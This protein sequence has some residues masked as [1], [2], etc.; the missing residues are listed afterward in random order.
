MSGKSDTSR[1][2]ESGWTP[3]SASLGKYQV[4]VMIPRRLA[5]THSWWSDGDRC[6]DARALLLIRPTHMLGAY[7]RAQV[8][9]SQR[10]R[11]GE[12]V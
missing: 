2:H 12:V 9:C 3:V 11:P 7:H 10:V 8:S 1:D 5:S 4:R 6:P